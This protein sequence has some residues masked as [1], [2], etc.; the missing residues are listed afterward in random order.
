[1]ATHKSLWAQY[2]VNRSPDPMQILWDGS[3]GISHD[4]VNFWEESIK[5]RW[6]KEDI[7]KK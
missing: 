1:M 4:L 6:L 2:L 3:L 5:A 7:F